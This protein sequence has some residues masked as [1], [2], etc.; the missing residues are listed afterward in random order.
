MACNMLRMRHAEFMTCVHHHACIHV[1]VASIAL[2]RVASLRACVDAR[3][4]HVVLQRQ[5]LAVACDAS[6]VD[7][8]IAWL[9]HP[10]IACMRA[11]RDMMRTAAMIVHLRVTNADKL[12]SSSCNVADRIIELVGQI[13]ACMTLM[14]SSCVNALN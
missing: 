5:R 10:C 11:G 12:S 1:D 9:M 7:P 6:G 8:R 4:M 2:S 13:P 3:I 14:R